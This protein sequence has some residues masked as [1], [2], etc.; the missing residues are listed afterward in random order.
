MDILILSVFA[1]VVVLSFMEDYM[2]SWQ[3]MLIL[4]TIG[5]ALI[6]ISAF[7]PMTT[8][9][10]VNYERYFYFHDDIIIEAMTEP[11]YRYLSRL[12]LS[13]GFGVIAMFLTYALI[14]VSIKLALLWKL[15]PFVFTAMVVYVGIYYPLHDVVQIRSGVSAAFLL[16]SII[17]LQKGRY[18]WATVLFLIATLFHYSSLAFLPILLVG[19]MEIGK[20]WKWILAVSPPICLLLYIAGFGAFSLVPG[21]AIEGKLD[22]YKEIGTNAEN[23]VPYKQITFL[24]EFVTLYIFLYFYDTIHRHCCYTPILVKMLALEMAYFTLF[25]DI[26]VLGMRLHDLFGLFNAFSYAC[27]LY[28]IRPQYAVRIGLAAFSLVHYIFRMVNELYFP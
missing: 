12:Y 17:P 15:T 13:M 27:L 4:I 21:N 7:K 1:L 24:A 25:A 3:K 26:E 16:W 2:P 9:D 28:I 6:C 23:Y 14:A 19:N 10:A 22:F 20:Y 8:A 11:T 18:L 5:I